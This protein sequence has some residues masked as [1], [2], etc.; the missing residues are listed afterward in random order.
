MDH[1]PSFSSVHRIE[2][3]QTA[4][5]NIYSYFMKNDNS[6]YVRPEYRFTSYKQESDKTYIVVISK[7]ESITGDYTYKNNSNSIEIECLI[8]ESKN[9]VQ[10]KKISLSSL[11]KTVKE[12][13]YSLPGT[14]EV[15]AD[16]IFIGLVFPDGLNRVSIMNMV[17]S[18]LKHSGFKGILILPASLSISLGLGISNSVV[19]SPSDRTLTLVEDNCIFDTITEGRAGSSTLYGSDIVEEFLKKEEVQ[20]NSSLDLICHMCNAPFEIAEFSVHFLNKHKIDIYKNPQKSD[21]IIRK[22]KVQEEPVKPEEPVQVDLVASGR[23]MVQRITPLERSKKITSTIILVTNHEVS[24]ENNKSPGESAG[25]EK[26]SS[27]EPIVI[28]EDVQDIS[29]IV[30]DTT[31]SVFL[32][33]QEKNKAQTAWNGMFALVNIEPSKEL[34]LT[35]KEW[36]SV[37]LRVLKE[38][39]LFSI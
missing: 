5:K 9:N 6:Y 28:P 18:V 22:C 33:V 15:R 20:K 1:S 13:A 3:I 25:P 30:E 29:K 16:K 36:N 35:D 24:A 38:K 4:N 19:F 2:G 32:Y 39:V 8:G 10:K 14:E 11:F 12:I 7:Y 27:E 23:D 21:E 37:G 31:G 17:D 34:W 26:A